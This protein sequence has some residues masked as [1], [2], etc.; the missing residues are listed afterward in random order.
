MFEHTNLQKNEATKQIKS[1]FSLCED[2]GRNLF[3]LAY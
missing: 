2:L 3:H 1:G